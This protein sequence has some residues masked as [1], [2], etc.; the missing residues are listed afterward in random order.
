M[1]AAYTRGDIAE[2]QMSALLMAIYFIGMTPTELNSWTAAMI[3]SGALPSGT[4]PDFGA[5]VDGAQA[6]AQ[7]RLAGLVD[8]LPR[9]NRCRHLRRR[10]FSFWPA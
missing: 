1:I 4:P 7:A 3:A 2:E 9:A 5:V 8:G 6:K 10:P